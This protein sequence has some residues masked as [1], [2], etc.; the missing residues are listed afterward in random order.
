MLIIPAIDLREGKCVRLVEGKVENE[1]IYSHDPVAVA[2]GWQELGARMLHLVDLDG[3]FTGKPYNRT[4]IEAIVREVKIPV[5]LGGGIR[6]LETIEELLNL[7]VNRVILGTVA[8]NQPALVR[9]AIQR[10]GEEAIVVGIDAKDGLVAIEGWEA[11][12][13]K[14]VGQLAREMVEIGV[15]R[16]VFTD[17]RRDGTLK[18]PNLDSIAALAR[19][20]GLRVIASGG[21]ATLAD[22]QAL[23]E[24]ESLGVEAVIV[25]KALYA[26]TVNLSEALE[27]CG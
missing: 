12:V 17:V 26:G 13:E 10:F 8:I 11:T 25:G 14:T 24:L 4:C 15:K 21:V 5:Q 1:T 16:V 2:L 23:K 22:L 20:S 27:V 7:G 19:E 9:E 6:S 18:G 3:A